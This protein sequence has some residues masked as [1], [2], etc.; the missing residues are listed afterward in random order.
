MEI[1]KYCFELSM[2]KYLRIS[3]YFT[4]NIG[5]PAEHVSIVENI[6]RSVQYDCSDSSTMQLI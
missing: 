6:H 2:K 5:I 1:C 4:F 3:I